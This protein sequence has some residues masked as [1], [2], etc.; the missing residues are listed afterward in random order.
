MRYAWTISGTNVGVTNSS[1]IE[2]KTHSIRWNLCIPDDTKNL[3]LNRPGAEGKTKHHGFAK[4]LV[5]IMH[6]THTAML[7]GIKEAAS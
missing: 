1:V 6:F 7:A 5:M 3:R 2:L 4:G